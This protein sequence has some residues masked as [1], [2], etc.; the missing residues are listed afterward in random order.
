MVTMG[1]IR[2]LRCGG[3]V[4][5][6]SAAFS[7]SAG[8]YVSES[9]TGASNG[10]ARGGLDINYITTNYDI[11][12]GYDIGQ[13]IVSLLMPDA[14]EDVIKGVGGKVVEYVKGKIISGASDTFGVDV[15]PLVDTITPKYGEDTVIAK[16]KGD[17][18]S[19]GILSVIRKFSF[20]NG[21][22][23]FNAVLLAI[24]GLIISNTFIKSLWAM[25]TLND[26][27]SSYRRLLMVVPSVAISIFSLM[28]TSNGLSG[29]QMVL[30]TAFLVSNYIGSMLVTIPSL[31]FPIIAVD[32]AFSFTSNGSTE[33][34]QLTQLMIATKNDVNIAA[35][36]LFFAESVVE[37]MLDNGLLDASIAGDMLHNAATADSDEFDGG[38][39]RRSPL[40][41]G[42]AKL[43]Y[44]NAYIQ[45]KAD[46]A[47]SGL[48]NLGGLT[49]FKKEANCFTS[50]KWDLLYTNKGCQAWFML[51]KTP[52]IISGSN[53]KDLSTKLGQAFY[54][55][56]KA[57]VIEMKEVVCSEMD[58]SER[59]SSFVCQIKDLNGF[60]GKQYGEV[61]P[62]LQPI[63][64]YKS[65][66]S[67][68][69]HSE[70]EKTYKAY[71]KKIIKGSSLGLSGG[72]SGR[73]KAEI[74][75]RGIVSTP[76]QILTKMMSDD[77]KNLVV[78]AHE[79]A[80]TDVVRKLYGLVGGIA[81]ADILKFIDYADVGMGSGRLY[82]PFACAINTDYCN[83]PTAQEDLSKQLVAF[84]KFGSI[85]YGVISG[86][87]AGTFGV[88][89]KNGSSSLFDTMFPDDDRNTK[90]IDNGG[91]GCMPKGQTPLSTPRE[92]G[93]AWMKA[94]VYGW[95]TG[96]MVESI[97]NLATPFLKK[98]VTNKLI[99]V[100]SAVKFVSGIAIAIG[101]ALC[102]LGTFIYI[103]ITLRMYFRCVVRLIVTL[104]AQPVVAVYALLN[105]FNETRTD[106]ENMS[107]SRFFAQSVIRMLVDCI[108]LSVA[109][110]VS[111]TLVL[112]AQ[113]IM[114]IVSR[115]YVWE[116]MGTDNIMGGNWLINILFQLSFPFIMC[117]CIWKC[118][119]LIPYL[120]TKIGDFVED[121]TGVQMQEGEDLVAEF[122]KLMNPKK[123]YGG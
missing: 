80:A 113:G 115:I 39:N 16:S 104:L 15:S 38:V 86:A 3:V 13:G 47:N 56:V 109:V 9:A 98:S 123:M 42:G 31:F 91:R 79:T 76:Y 49:V 32:S 74:Y 93:M 73:Q 101:V 120:F 10:S 1:L 45:Q 103:A 102:Y 29:G 55:A 121:R 22:M 63:F 36:N 114:S 87:S 20:E 94:G 44:T 106:T 58:A 68:P 96:E 70:V 43:S 90:C 57:R 100:G 11:H 53:D 67:S 78:N 88:K 19:H 51:S 60:T 77:G 69:L 110:L 122:K 108:C 12:K 85:F 33:D 6:C 7:A 14:V 34:L 46:A 107:T 59:A 54:G 89:H 37:S 30:L 116:A 18:S 66:D 72:N 48:S 105:G 25:M 24:A 2:F 84:S 75:I 71:I 8:T 35:K 111:L 92:D 50:P 62:I 5:C 97:G 112:F 61:K 95:I 119:R 40:F 117:W 41:T 82:S 118:A 83:K 27:N 21:L 17:V 26:G 23:Y 65:F 64:D 52:N 4:L 81:T 28:P 99:G